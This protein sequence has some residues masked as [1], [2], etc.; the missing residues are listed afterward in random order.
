M[1]IKQLLDFIPLYSFIT[2]LIEETKC[3]VGEEALKLSD[4]ELRQIEKDYFEKEP[5]K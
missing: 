4:Q 2:H 1:N 3:E 5:H